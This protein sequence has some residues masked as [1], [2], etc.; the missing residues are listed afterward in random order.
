MNLRLPKLPKKRPDESVHPSD[1][2]RPSEPLS[3]DA[4]YE[5]LYQDRRFSTLE[6][7]DEG[8]REASAMDFLNPP[9][10]R[11]V[12]ALQ[13]FEAWRA[14]PVFLL[15]GFCLTSL[16]T[17]AKYLVQ[18]HSLFLVVWA[19]Y[20]GQMLVVAPIAWHRAG[21]GF[22]RT[23][24]LSLQLQ[25][26]AMLLGATVCL[27]GGLRY[28]PLAEGSAI[29]FLAPML[30][31]M[32]SGPLLRE[33]PTRAR[34]VASI[35]GFVGVLILLRPGSAVFHPA[36]LLLLGAALFNAFY[37]M[38][39]RK[40]IY[41]DVY[42]TLFHSALVGT[43]VLTAALPWGFDQTRSH[44]ERWG[45]VAAAR[46]AC[47]TWPLVRDRRI[48][49]RTC[50]AIVSVH[51]RADDLGRGLWVR[52]LR[53]AAGPLVDGR[54]LRDRRERRVSRDNGAPAE[55]RLTTRR[56]RPRRRLLRFPT[57]DYNVVNRSRW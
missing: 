53:P 51:L 32:L 26:S 10:Q 52:N 18:D 46:V 21:N 24:H 33:K 43:V 39:T 27:Y 57:P 20:V 36:A 55:A 3:P 45:S 28:L 31:V 9:I 1:A 13:D 56:P 23:R 22:W 41:E 44:P 6:I 47:R 19:R 49:P 5:R 54:H 50:L 8:V 42:T 29:L 12:R 35:T 16:D 14:L 38:L 48:R 25:R 11:V 7:A 2:P 15:A 34:W 30:I 37:N 4:G 17:T 40:L